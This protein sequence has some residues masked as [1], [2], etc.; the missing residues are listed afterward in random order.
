MKAIVRGKYRFDVPHHFEHG[1]K[2]YEVEVDLAEKTFAKGEI[3]VE[4]ARVL[5]TQDKLFNSLKTH[6]IQ[7][8][9]EPPVV[10]PPVVETP[11]V[12]GLFE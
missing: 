3:L 10:E 1:L 11:G 2:E 8:V 5:K 6:D 4:V 7:V 9:E 12:E